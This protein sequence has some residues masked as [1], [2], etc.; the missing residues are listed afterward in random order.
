MVYAGFEDGRFVGYFSP[1]SYTERGPGVGRA[2]SISWQPYSLATINFDVSN[3]SGAL[4]GISGKVVNES[5]SLGS[6]RDTTA[7][8]QTPLGL[9]FAANDAASCTANATSNF[10]YAPCTTDCCDGS[11]RNYY[12]SAPESLGEAT[13]FTRWRVYDARRRPWYIQQKKMHI[14][15]NA[16]SMY[17][18][19]Y[20]FATSQ[21]LGLTATATAIDDVTGDLMGIFAMV[22]HPRATHFAVPDG[23]AALACNDA[24]MRAHVYSGL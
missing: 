16:T 9:Q 20:E 15:S 22:R 5:C 18:S 13:T 3:S 12:Y 2:S 1:Q 10:W 24:E 6:L 7:A 21:A 17:S 8:C 23:C 14:L 19:A 11:I 4:R